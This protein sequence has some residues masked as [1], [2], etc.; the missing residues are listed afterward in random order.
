MSNDL[1]VVKNLVKHFPIRKGVFSKTVGAVRAVDGVSFSIPKGQTLSLV[2]ESGSGKTTTG[3]AILRLI[4]PTSGTVVFDGMDV[5]QLDRSGMRDLRKRIQIIFQD[6]F[7]SL[8]PRMTVYAVLAE[9]LKVHGLAEKSKRRTRVM[10]LL[11][12][13]GLPPEAA[14]RYPHEFSGGQR[15]RIGIA[16]ALAVEPDLIVADE[17]VSALDV[18]VQAQILNL[19][20]DLQDKLGLTYLFIG[21]DLSVVQHLSDTVAVMYLGRIV[22]IAPTEQLFK[23]PVHPYTRALLSAVPVADPTAKK[24]RILLSGDAPS[25]INPPSGCFFHPRCPECQPACSEQVPTLVKTGEDHYVAC[26]VHTDAKTA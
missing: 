22:E 9:I 14:D 13:V 7:G 15:Q 3:R 11:D 12:L 26:P 23:N 5:T 6:P 2:G 8:N 1:L 17:P 16:R 21:H 24:E 4:E 20:E 18:S 10:E 19:M 25:P